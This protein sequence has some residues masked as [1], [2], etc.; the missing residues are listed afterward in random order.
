L[1]DEYGDLLEMSSFLLTSKLHFPLA[2]SHLVPRP[3]LIEILEKGLRGPLTLISAPPGSGKTTLMGEWHVISKSPMPV[4]WLSLDA[5]DNDPLRFLTYLTVA[6]ESAS[7]GLVRTTAAL[8]QAPQPPPFQALVTTLLESLGSLANEIVLVLDDYHVITNIVIHE[9]L[10]NLLAYLP[11]S[12]HLVLLTRADPPLPLSRLRAHNELTEIRANDLRFTADEALAFLSQTMGLSLSQ[13]QSAWL[14]AKTEG[15]IA[16][17][18]LAAL[19][20]QRRDDVQEFISTFTGGNRYIVDYLTEEVLNCQPESTQAFLLETSILDRMN[21]ALCNAV[22][23][24]T[25]AQTL[26]DYLERNNL[27]IIALDDERGWYRY[28][29]LFADQLRAYLSRLRS[30]QVPLLQ[31]RAAEW[32]AQHGL[33]EEAIPYALKANDFEYAALLLKEFSPT[34]SREGRIA[35]LSNWIGALPEAIVAKR[36]QLGFSLAWALYLE[37]DFDQAEA[38]VLQVEQNLQTQVEPLLRGE[39]AFWHGVFARRRAEL[40]RS[41]DFLIQALEQLP[42]ENASLRGRA[43]IFLGMVYLESDL[44]RAEQTLIQAVDTYEAQNLVQGMLPSLYFLARTQRLQGQLRKADVTCQRALRIAEEAAHWPIASYAHLAVAEQHYERGELEPATEHLAKGTELAQLGGYTDNLY[45]ATLDTAC[46][47]RA[48]G[49]WE[50]SQELL[51]KA[52][53][54][55][56]SS[57]PWVHVRIAY[58][59]LSLFMAQGKL[60]EAEEWLQQNQS[61]SEAR[62]SIPALQAQMI[63]ARMSVARQEA[64]DVLEWL[65]G[66]LEQAQHLGLFRWVIQ[67]YCL[68]SL[69]LHAQ[70]RTNEA[71]S[72][73]ESALALAEPEGYVEVFL[74][75]DPHI[76]E[77]IRMAQKR[78]L[79]PRF[80]ARLIEAFTSR[81]SRKEANPVSYQGPL[82]KREIELVHLIAE[83]CSNKEIAAQLVISLG[84]VKRHT[85]N[86]FTKLGV[87]NRTEAVAKA[88]QMGLL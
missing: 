23:G 13:E 76:L 15:W 26:L 42:V 60:K 18:Q 63:Y 83:G 39:L 22:T 56:R 84:T 16:G 45:L 36:P 3:R 69:A 41:R 31:H 61:L 46:V 20:L 9:A 24:K 8:L 32:C 85:V 28:H 6:L 52:N 35:T 80:V 64:R 27:F 62:S 4:A 12:L 2:R 30:E 70:K 43:G 14:G 5:A 82:S 81:P 87:K 48:C 55:A 74:E 10:N 65:E 11:S 72:K 17:L 40:D 21:T 7:P 75:E 47:Q 37:Y 1:Y 67:I 50:K 54:L 71:L 73:L 25:D 57:I 53:D 58:E 66:L 77:L 78:E 34:L 29:H 49:N 59:Q 68:Q 33:I 51:M 79:A 86:I 88:R 44:S 19:S 38:R